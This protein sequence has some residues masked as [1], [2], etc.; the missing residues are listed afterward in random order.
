MFIL[1]KQELS[2]AM[3][4]WDQHQE[5]NSI[6]ILLVNKSGLFQEQYVTKNSNRFCPGAFGTKSW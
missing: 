6:F 3:M 2:T 1:T 4:I 5:K